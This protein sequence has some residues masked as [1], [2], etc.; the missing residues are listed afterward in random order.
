MFL[1]VTP[2][3]KSSLVSI[4]HSD[5]SICPQG[6]LCTLLLNVHCVSQGTEEVENNHVVW[7]IN[8]FQMNVLP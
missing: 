6:H 5:L 2:Y 4:G 1:W 8:L 3:T 7:M